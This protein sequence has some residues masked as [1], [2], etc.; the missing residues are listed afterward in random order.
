MFP[1]TDGDDTLS[2]AGSSLS[3]FS[4]TIL[5]RTSTS[6]WSTASGNVASVAKILP[7]T[8]SENKETILD[9]IEVDPNPDGLECVGAY[10][11]DLN[12][13]DTA[14]MA[15]VPDPPIFKIEAGVNL[16]DA[17]FDGDVNAAEDAKKL[18]A[19]LPTTCTPSC[20]SEF[21]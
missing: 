16:Q 8:E 19:S 5:Y 1:K 18:G 3:V 7:I 14:W 4:D 12:I 11:A 2:T 13:D 15:S 21:P 20:L 10:V 9:K 17:L 6:I